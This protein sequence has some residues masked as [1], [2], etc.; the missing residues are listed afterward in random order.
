MPLY[1]YKCSKCGSVFEFFQKVEDPSPEKCPKCQGPLKK[2]LS[3][4][5]L[6]FKGSG[7]YVTDYA[8]KKGQGSESDGQTKSKKDK[9]ASTQK[10]KTSAPA[11]KK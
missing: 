11:P 7:W 9:D 3:A 1:E 6:Q 5:A 8:A 10:E 2:V 4:P